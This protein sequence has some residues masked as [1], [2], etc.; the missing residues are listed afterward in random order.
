MRKEFNDFI[1]VINSVVLGKKERL[2]GIDEKAVLEIARAH[3]MTKIA[4]SH[5]KDIDSEVKRKNDFLDYKHIVRKREYEEITK[6]L[7]KV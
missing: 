1:K 4:L 3:D 2:S 7:L 6:K 5:I